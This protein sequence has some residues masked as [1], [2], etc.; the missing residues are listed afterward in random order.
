MCKV[1]QHFSEL[2]TVSSRLYRGSLHCR[3]AARTFRRP[4]EWGKGGGGGE[5]GTKGRPGSESSSCSCDIISLLNGTFSVV[6]QST[7]FCSSSRS[8]FRTAMDAS[9]SDVA[10]TGPMFRASSFPRG[11]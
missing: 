7:R 10:A 8:D 6:R 4:G 1:K 9:R 3:V 11:V 2:S 5:G